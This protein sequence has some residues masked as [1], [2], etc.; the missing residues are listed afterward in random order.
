MAALGQFVWFVFTAGGA[1]L[2]FLCAL[3]LVLHRP[4]SRMRRR[5]AIAVALFYIVAAVHAVPEAV[6]Q[7]L[8]GGLVPVERGDLPSSPL[9]IVVLGAGSVTVRDWMGNRYVTPDPHAAARVLEAVRVFRMD[10]SATVIGSGGLLSPDT[11][12]TPTGEAIAGAL[13]A[14]GVPDSQLLVATEGRNTHEEAVVVARMLRDRPHGTIV[15]VTADI[16]MRRAIGT[17]RA[18]GLR[19]IPAIARSP[20]ADIRPRTRWIP[21]DLGLWYSG[22]VVHEILGISYYALRG[23]FMS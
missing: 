1:A 13:R 19:V 17:F 9:T 23:W 3:L 12:G 5:L 18:A 20:D 21:S 22:F 7:L 11:P 2:A 8:V 4:T 14:L 15:L 16:H 10:P 6:G